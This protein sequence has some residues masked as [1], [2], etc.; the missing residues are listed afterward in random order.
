LD[1]PPNFTLY[2]TQIDWFVKSE[3]GDREKTKTLAQINR[4]ISDGVRIE[5]PG[6]SRGI[7]SIPTSYESGA[8]GFL[9]PIPTQK[10]LTLIKTW[11]N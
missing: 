3:F 9:K 8:L 1:D 10:I 5:S 4:M 6:D 11:I 7:I 2:N